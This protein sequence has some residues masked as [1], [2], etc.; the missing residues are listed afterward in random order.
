MRRMMF[1]LIFGVSLGLFSQ[2]NPDTLPEKYVKKVII[3]AKWGNG[4]GEFGLEP[5]DETYTWQS[6]LAIDNEGNFYIVDANNRRIN[7]YN[8]NGKFIKEIKVP[9]EFLTYIGEDTIATIAGIGV[10]SKNFL[11][12]GVA[13]TFAFGLKEQGKVISKLDKNGNIVDTYIFKG[14]NVQIPY[15]LEDKNGDM[16]VW[17]S[18]TTGFSKSSDYLGEAFIP[19]SKTKVMDNSGKIGMITEVKNLAAKTFKIINKRK[20]IAYLNLRE[21][22]QKKWIIHTC[23]APRVFRLIKR[24]G[25]EYIIYEDWLGNITIET[26]GKI[27]FKKSLRNLNTWFFKHPK[28]GELSVSADALF[29]KDGNFY[30][31]KGDANGFKLIKYIVNQEVWK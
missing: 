23:V 14:I 6:H 18:W 16:Y 4:P 8:Q 12:I 30:L 24:E 28:Y 27:L 17:G 15:F 26:E 7:V 13:S 21:F 29:D 3:E 22:N 5:I 31:I 20:N 9:P 10:D 11:Y 1:V 25:K 2:V 19:L